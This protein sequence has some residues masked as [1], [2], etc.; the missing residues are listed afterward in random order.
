MFILSYVYTT[1]IML[2]DFVMLTFGMTTMVSM[3]VWSIILGIIFALLYA[4]LIILCKYSVIFVEKN[5]KK[6]KLSEMDI[7]YLVTST[8]IFV[9][10]GVV[11]TPMYDINEVANVWSS[12]NFS[13]SKFFIEPIFFVLIYIAMLIFPLYFIAEAF[14][15]HDIGVF[16][17]FIGMFLFM[18]ANFIILCKYLYRFVCKTIKQEPLSQKDSIFLITSLLVFVTI[19]VIFA[20]GGGSV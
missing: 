6:E 7:Y 12:Y 20:V 13:I 8:V 14:L 19:G 11:L 17:E 9:T 2:T 4:N 3:F 10:V 1:I 5:I 15:Q 18:W 16:F